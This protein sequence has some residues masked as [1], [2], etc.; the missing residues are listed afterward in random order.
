MQ[1]LQPGTV[2]DVG[3]NL[4]GV[5]VL[6]VVGGD[7]GPPS[8]ANVLAFGAQSHRVRHVDPVRLLFLLLTKLG[9][10][11]ARE[12]STSEGSSVVSKAP[13]DDVSVVV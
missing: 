1:H 11:V 6:P 3:D 5:H 4:L 12:G 2:N 9:Y 10:D 13:P 8:L 7:E